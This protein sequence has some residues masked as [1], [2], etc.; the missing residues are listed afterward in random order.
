MHTRHAKSGAA[1]GAP[2]VLP[3]RAAVCIAAMMF[4]GARAHTTTAQPG[5][6]AGKKVI[7][8]GWDMP[9]AI[10]F[11]EHARRL[12]NTGLDGVVL[13]FSRQNIGDNPGG[14]DDVYDMR[15]WW[16]HWEPVQMDQIQ[17]NIDAIRNVDVGRL[18]HN[19]L[20]MYTSSN[21]TNSSPAQFFIWDK[22]RY[23]TSKFKP[24][25]PGKPMDPQSWPDD[26]YQYFNAFKH[27]MVTAARICRELGLVGFCIDQETYDRDGVG[28]MYHPWVMEVFDEDLETLRA[29]MRK[30]VAEVFRAVCEEFPD[31][32]ILLIPGGRYVAEYEH[33]DGLVKAFTDGMLMGLGPRATLHDGQEKAYDI[34]MHKRFVAL[35]QETRAAGLKYSAVPDLYR[36]RMQYSYGIWLDFR[37]VSYGGWYEDDYLNHFTARDFGDAL[38]DALYESDRYVWI[39][40]ENAIMWPAD[41]RKDKK[42][43]V[44]EAYY[45]AIRNCKEPRPL[46]R[47]RDSRGAENEPMPG[48]A[49]SY[50]SAGDRFDTAA[51]A[52][53]SESPELELIAQIDEGWEISFDP[54][55]I[56]MWSGGIRAPG[57]EDRFDWHPIRVGEFWENQGYQYNGPAFYRVNFKVDEKYR[58]RKVYIVMG[59]IANKCAI[60]LNTWEWIYGIY[61]G[62]PA[63]VPAREPLKFP[64]RGIKFGDAENEFRVYVRNPRGPG[65]I[66]KPVWI[67]VDK[68]DRADNN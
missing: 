37:S 52:A 21:P 30:N 56:G 63:P 7:Q 50:K 47:L 46:N 27:N 8:F 68:Q 33:H 44:P 28:P 35:K 59:G 23:D 39:Y 25:R 20:S 43:N 45:E 48:P 64:A 34:G 49:A 15:Y 6:I 9:W 11:A 38:H 13:N 32:Q 3:L 31:I 5:T 62:P 66:Y 41:W 57:G 65:G 61:K 18:K 58:G 10:N 42:P 2:S 4:I 53:T 51:S 14:Q 12:Q 17:H 1:P 36:N 24:L 67:A 54:E 29:R 26:P 16:V 40:T 55:D 60:H 19:F 22:T